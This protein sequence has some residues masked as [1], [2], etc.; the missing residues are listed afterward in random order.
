[1]KGSA[2]RLSTGLPK[3]PCI[4][5]AFGRRQ[6]QG[7]VW[8]LRTYVQIHCDDMVYASYGEQVGEHPGSDGTS[9]TLLLG[10]AGVGEVSRLGQ[11]CTRDQTER[12]AYGMTA[13][14]S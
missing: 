14:T 10:L 5:D 8:K 3:K 4:C 6:Y 13:G 9:M 1:M 11:P 12:A 2:K 7:K